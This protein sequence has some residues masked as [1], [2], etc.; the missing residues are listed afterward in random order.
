MT[1]GYVGD[2]VIEQATDA[3]RYPDEYGDSDNLDL[4]ELFA[5]RTEDVLEQRH[6]TQEMDSGD[7]ASSERRR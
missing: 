4:E 3:L 1:G 7:E 6:Q 5:E 2:R